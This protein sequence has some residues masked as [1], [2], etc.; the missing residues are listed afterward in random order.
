MITLR[1]FAKRAAPIG[2]P[3]L[4]GAIVIG[5]TPG[6]GRA[7]APAPTAVAIEVPASATIGQEIMVKARLTS[8]GAPVTSRLLELL[9]DGKTLRTASVDSNGSAL[10][11][12]RTGELVKAHQATVTVLF[13]GGAA[14]APAAGSA[15]LNVLPARL[16]IRTVPAIDGIPIDVGTLKAT[17]ANGG[18]AVFAI[19]KLGTYRANADIAAVSTPALRAD[20]VRWGDNIYTPERDVLI[21]GDTELDLGLHTAVRGSFRFVNQDG[22]LI[23]PAKIQS[24]TLTSTS[25]S[26]LVLTQYVGVW[27]EAGS[28][29]KRLDALAESPRSWRVLDVEMSGTNVVN[30]GQQRVDP[31]PNAT[32]TVTVLLFDLHVQGRDALFGNSLGGRLELV[33]PDNSTRVV[34]LNGSS[35]PVDFLQLPRGNY[36]LRLSGAGLGAPTPVVLSQTQTATIRVVTF[37]D[38][39]VFGALVLAAIAAVLWIGRRDQVLHAGRLVRVGWSSARGKAATRV[40]SGRHSAARVIGEIAG[41]SGMSP[42]T[43]RSRLARHWRVLRAEATTVA[44]AINHDVR[45]VGRWLQASPRALLEP[46]AASPPAPPEEALVKAVVL[47]PSKPP[48]TQEGK[49]AP[50]KLRS[51][52]RK[53]VRASTKAAKSPAQPVEKP[54]STSRKRTGTSSAAKPTPAPRR[55]AA[56]AKA[57][58]ARRATKGTGTAAKPRASSKQPSS[59]RPANRSAARPR[60]DKKSPP[61]RTRSAAASAR[62]KPRKRTIAPSEPILPAPL[63]DQ[64]PDPVP[65]APAPRWAEVMARTIDHSAMPTALSNRSGIRESSQTFP[66]NC[67]HCGRRV[68]AN[69]MYC[70]SCGELLRVP[71]RVGDGR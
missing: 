49:G 34:E 32:W 31:A 46:R 69:A 55:R 30:R 39:G 26:Q 62:P 66:E 52:G 63:Q 35:G 36:T 33:Y 58:P 43:I 41:R 68:T 47:S 18:V 51:P 23:D 45:Q 9:L 2:L 7:A 16:T 27:L 19:P 5:V 20:F 24:V 57:S 4:L 10:L 21:A 17:T 60:T 25:G 54:V 8:N 40:S 65:D 28:A 56:S 53:T 22:T 71:G 42:R 13:S 37:L 70:R 15:V 61:P 67:P 29:V 6:P 3:L 11:P 1:S 38:I 44:V 50:L 14:L 64:A 59:S 48:S 12:I